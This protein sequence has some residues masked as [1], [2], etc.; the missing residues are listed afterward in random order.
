MHT[1]ADEI[2]LLFCFD[3]KII[4]KRP[5][6]PGKVVFPQNHPGFRHLPPSFFA[7][8]GDPAHSC[9]LKMASRA[10]AI[11]TVFQAGQRGSIQP[12]NALRSPA[13]RCFQTFTKRIIIFR[14]SELS[15]RATVF[16][17]D[18]ENCS[19]FFFLNQVCLH[20]PQ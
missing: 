17:Q 15:P 12:E 1:L 8:L 16:P 2:G 5:V 11:M 14:L 4:C 6:R 9:A 10:P 19:F 18:N 7:V 20:L 13:L 3:V